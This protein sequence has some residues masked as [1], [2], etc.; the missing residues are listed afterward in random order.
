MSR[1]RP[2]SP[3]VNL[4]ALIDGQSVTEEPKAFTIGRAVQV[5]SSN[6][7]TT[8]A[9][10]LEIDP[11]V[12]DIP[13]PKRRRTE[14]SGK[15][16][17]DPHVEI[18]RLENELSDMRKRL[19]RLESVVEVFEE[20][21][22]ESSSSGRDDTDDDEDESDT[23]SDI[24]SDGS[25]VLAVPDGYE[26]IYKQLFDIL[27]SGDDWLLHEPYV[28]EMA[29]NVAIAFYKADQQFKLR[30]DAISDSKEREEYRVAYETERCTKLSAI[31]E[32]CQT[33][34]G[35]LQY[36]TMCSQMV[37]SIPSQLEAKRARELAAHAKSKRRSD[38]LR[39]W[40]VTGTLL[41]GFMVSSFW[42]YQQLTLDQ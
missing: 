11:I 16:S 13:G 26:Y 2:N 41:C 29:G 40:A 6:E 18:K 37:M 14:S 24:S 22:E 34:K 38:R 31:V 30:A 28:H 1:S 25:E 27:V 3:D 7:S 19:E 35:S 42:T 17:V 15:V 36:S 5:D 32:S 39:S 10:T 4:D 21:T 23:D 9:T 12:L 33:I 20:E 8:T